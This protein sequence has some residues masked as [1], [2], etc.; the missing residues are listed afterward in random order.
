MNPF[1]VIT[2]QV[3]YNEDGDWID[4]LD[5]YLWKNYQ[6]LKTFFRDNLP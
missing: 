2:L 3:A 6:A 4:Q 1:S 5:V